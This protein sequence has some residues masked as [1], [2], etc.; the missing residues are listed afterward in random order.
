MT[1]VP[2]QLTGE[3]WLACESELRH[4][5]DRLLD[6]GHWFGRVGCLA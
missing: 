1:V 6:V 3:R 4:A 5:I 2:G